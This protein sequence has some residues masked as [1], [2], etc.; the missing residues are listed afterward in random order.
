VGD[1]DVMDT[2][3]T[4]SLTPQIACAW[5][6]DP[7]LFARTFPMDLRPQ[8]PEIIRTWLFSTL[9]R[10]L[11]EH[12]SLP[13]SDATINGWILDPDRKKMSKS[14]G[15]VVTPMPLLDEHG[16]DAVRYWACR[17]APG[18]D[19][20]IDYSVMK[21]GRRLAIKLLNASKF[22][23][24]LGGA[25]ADT[26]TDAVT[27]PLDRAMLAALAGVAAEATTAFDAY[28]YTRALD[29]AETFFWH[30]CDDYVELVKGRAYGDGPEAASARAAL[31]L[32]LST[33]QRL[34]APFLPF[35]TE[36]VW[37]W[38]QEGSVHRAAWPDGLDLAAVAGDGDPQVLAVTAEAL[39]EVR[40]AKTTAKR[41]LR[42]DV[43]RAVVT[44]TPARLAALRV[45]EA[46]LRDA[47]RIAELILVDGDGL[48]VDV[49]L[50]S[51][52]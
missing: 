35:A 7:D 6:D 41:S 37:S 12:D 8:G 50:A 17:G 27:E 2:W 25:G 32:A 28:D 11:L 21:V 4:S 42:T 39:G 29:R 36:E 26:A 51:P 48:T 49:E 47:G 3:A 46:D 43:T 40:K 15:N 33:L 16:P 24:G 1:P 34:F 10:S 23:L 20:A 13:W 19:T 18:T 14:K 38:W 5:E 31:G 44:D 30:F 52:D 22:V 9:L 45:A